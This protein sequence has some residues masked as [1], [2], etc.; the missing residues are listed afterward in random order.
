AAGGRYDGLV[1]ELGGSHSPAVGFGAGM[2][3]AVLALEAQG[4]LDARGDGLQVFV[5]SLGEAARAHA[6]ALAATLRG[7]GVA[8]GIDYRDRPELER[9]L[10]G[11][12]KAAGRSGAAFAVILGDEEI[13]RGVAAIK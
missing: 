5:V 2:E 1:E 13:A 8:T 4:A 6:V 10:K 9:S 7:L 12:M 11:Q 3:R